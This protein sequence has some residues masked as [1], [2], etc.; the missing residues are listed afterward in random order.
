MQIYIPNRKYSI[1]CKEDSEDYNKNEITVLGNYSKS[2]Y[3]ATCIVS[4][5]GISPTIR[6]NHGQLT[7]VLEVEDE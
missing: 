2:N 3:N 5:Y 7:A 4:K 1:E 6:E